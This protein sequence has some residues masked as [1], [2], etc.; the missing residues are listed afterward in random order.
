MRRR[1][2]LR[3]GG[4]MLGALVALGGCTTDSLEAAESQPP[5]VEEAAFDPAELD[6]PV[7]EK[8]DVVEAGVERGHDAGPGDPDEFEE[9]LRS[10]EIDVEEVSEDGATLSLEYVQDPEGGV[11]G[12]FGAVVGTYAALVEEGYEGDVLEVEMLD[13]D[14]EPFGSYDVRTEWAEAYNDGELSTAEYGEKAMKTIE[15]E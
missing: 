8:T 9:A 14:T 6:L 4:T 7:E 15:T 12:P 3:R 11:L 5:F 1:T 13:P 10:R 2:A